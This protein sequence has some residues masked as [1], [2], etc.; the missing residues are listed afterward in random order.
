M[1]TDRVGRAR[2][3]FA[4]LLALAVPAGMFLHARAT[5]YMD[6]Q[7]ATAA[8]TRALLA[9]SQEAERARTEGAAA[10]ETPGTRPAEGQSVALLK[11]ID[12]YRKLLLDQKFEQAWELIHPDTYG[13]WEQEE[14]VDAQAE[15]SKGDLSSLS[16]PWAVLL[17]GKG[18]E[19][20]DTVIKG[21]SGYARVAM[22]LEE[23]STLLLRKNGDEWAI[24]LAGTT[25]AE[26]RN[27]LQSQLK[28]L[29]ADRPFERMFGFAITAQEGLG[30]PTQ[31]P[32]NAL[33]VANY[34][35]EPTGMKIEGDHATVNLV[36]R[37]RVHLLVPVELEE[38]SWRPDWRNM[39]I[40]DPSQPTGPE[41]LG[42]RVASKSTQAACQ[43]NMKQLGLA[44]LM[45][46]QDYDEKMPIADR[47][48]D[49]VFPY[50]KNEAIFTCPAD[51]EQWSYAMNYKLSRQLMARIEQPAWTIALF[52]SEPSRRNAWDKDAPA[53]ASLASP[54]RHGDFNNFAFTDGHVKALRTPEVRPEMYRLVGNPGF[55][56]PA[57][58][59]PDTPVPA[60]P[61][62]GPAPAEPGE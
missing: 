43:S 2:V 55:L 14:W 47:W 39:E 57:P 4:V 15:L 62:P 22:D 20:V 38:G 45:Y 8:V 53:G 7:L 58:Q 10:T 52:E 50:C 33:P 1:R 61:A 59:G 49:A 32:I 24:D 18:H 3:T 51:K 13:G 28:L 42:R 5:A 29:Q 54:P 48:C 44:L 25:N 46:C 40:I 26:A 34:R 36:A 30:I 37:G 9:V 21:N 41:A 19:V 17:C 31:F 11:A 16:E 12:N 23:R 35:C 60:P 6:S 56:A 27:S